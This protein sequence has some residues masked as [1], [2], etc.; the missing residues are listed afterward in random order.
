MLKRNEI[1]CVN[2]KRTAP[3]IKKFLHNSTYC[4]LKFVNFKGA[5]SIQC[6]LLNVFTQQKVRGWSTACYTGRPLYLPFS[7]PLTA[8]LSKFLSQ[9]LYVVPFPND[10]DPKS[11]F[12]RYFFSLIYHF[13]LSIKQILSKFTCM[14]W[15]FPCPSEKK[16][17]Q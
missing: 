10:L 17:S 8:Q 14:T 12:W 4:V 7:L 2:T 9:P 11:E 3:P 13:S 6:V 16:N 1:S 15:L 5:H